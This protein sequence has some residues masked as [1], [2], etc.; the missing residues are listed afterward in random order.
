MLHYTTNSL[1]P[2]QLVLNLS[3][4]VFVYFILI[5]VNKI[6]VSQEQY[7]YFVQLN[8]LSF[9]RKWYSSKNEAKYY[10]VFVN[11]NICSNQQYKHLI[12]IELKSTFY[13]LLLY[14]SFI[15]YALLIKNSFFTR[16]LPF[17]NVNYV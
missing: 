4:D 3:K 15:Y 17:H 9:S 7:T 1:V 16:V 5:K 11:K 12:F 10:K 14:F 2:L 6:Y 13:I 8:T